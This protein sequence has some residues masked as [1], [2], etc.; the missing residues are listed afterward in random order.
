MTD[1]AFSSHW[2]LGNRSLGTIW[3]ADITPAYRTF[4]IRCASI[5]YTPRA[6][7]LSDLATECR[8]HEVAKSL[9]NQARGVQPAC[10]M[11]RLHTKLRARL[12]SD[13]ATE[14]RRHKVA[15]SLGN[16]A[17]GVQPACTMTTQNSKI[18]L[19]SSIALKSRLI[20]YLST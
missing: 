18:R 7:L 14:C 15:K 19:I 6:R 8:R 4:Y 5:G 10:T 1:M 16:Q 11:Y 9:G 3:S 13:L 12:L 2:D 20:T 17:Q